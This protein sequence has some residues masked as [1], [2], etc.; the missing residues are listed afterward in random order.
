MK[1]LIREYLA[2]LRESGEFDRLL[3]ELLLAMD[4]IP[5]S[6]AQVGVKQSGVDISARGKT[7][8]GRDCLYL[9]VLKRGDLGRSDWDTGVNAIRPSLNEIK[10]TYLT[11]HILPDDEDKLKL[12]IVSSTGDLKQETKDS[13]EGYV[14]SNTI[15]GRVE[16]GFWNADFLASLIEK[17]LFNEHLLSDLDKSDLRKALSLI[18]EAEGAL[19]YFYSF[20][21]RVLLSK[22]MDQKQLIRALRTVNLSTNILLSWAESEGNLAN[23][24]KVVERSVLWGWEAVRK[25]GFQ[26]KSKI[27]ENYTKVTLSYMTFLKTYFNKL[28]PYCYARDAISVYSSE[29][30]LI[31]ETI[32]EQIG[33]LAII[34]LMHI[35][36][37]GGS[38]EFKEN[39]RIVADALANLLANNPMSGSPCFDDHSNEISMALLLFY[40]TGYFGDAKKWLRTLVGRITYSFANGRNFPAGTDSLDDLIEYNAEPT[41]RRREK[42]IAVSTLLPSLA[43]WLVVF[44]IESSY[45]HLLSYKES[46]KDTCM[47]LWYPDEMTDEH[48]YFEPAQYESGTSEA[49]IQF[50]STM[51]Q[52]A[53]QVIK[54]VNSKHFIEI[55]EQDFAKN[56]VPLLDLIANRHFRTPVHPLYW[57]RIIVASSE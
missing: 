55:D 53:D 43:Q 37:Q 46:F 52:F 32:F 13:W 45:L 23:A 47:Q 36:I 51:S 5:L 39:A 56:G 27:L 17:H 42:L 33:I 48:L 29:S 11:S 7:P 21:K 41:D 49:P 4:I 50:P 14:K 3:P 9:F 2:L 22:K 54:I 16:F 18:G 20:L 15:A 38:D 40:H 30:I 31:S 25:N 57:Q 26:K 6:K 34:G 19:N 10:D 28:Q 1:L 35:E 8:D 24:L 44:K 12:I